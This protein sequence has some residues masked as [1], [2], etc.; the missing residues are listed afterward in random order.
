MV[1]MV[2]KQ[3][4]PQFSFLKFVVVFFFLVISAVRETTEP[5]EIKANDHDPSIHVIIKISPNSIHYAA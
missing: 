4:I 3:I 5:I 2:M 1:E